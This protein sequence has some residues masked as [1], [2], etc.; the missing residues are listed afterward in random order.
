MV[1]TICLLAALKEPRKAVALT[2]FF[3]FLRPFLVN[4][5]IVGT[6]KIFQ[7]LINLKL[8]ITNIGLIGPIG[9]ILFGIFQ[10]WT[11]NYYII[12]TSKI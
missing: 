7:I 3:F 2:T 12:P 4:W 8:Q 11:V 1:L 6:I 5:L 10:L 9:P